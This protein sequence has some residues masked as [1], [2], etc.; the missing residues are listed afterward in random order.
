[1]NAAFIVILLIVIFAAI[2]MLNFYLAEQRRK[3]LRTWASAR[4]LSFQSCRDD[5]LAALHMGFSCFERGGNRYAYN[6]AQGANGQR[7]IQAFD[8]HYETK[9][10]KGQ[11]HHHR[12]SAVVV[13]AGLP[14]K[15]LSIRGET[16]FDG[17]GT[18]FGLGDIELES[19]EFNRRFHVTSPD[20]RWAFDALP[21]ATM[22]FLLESP[23]FSIEIQYD[24]MIA[25]TGR[26][27]SAPDFDAALNVL[28]GFLDRIP[29]TVLQELK[30]ACK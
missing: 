30:D 10:S 6:I 21:Q 26:V 13:R 3:E 14:L 24:C 20:R 18:F 8:Y 9:G 5:S 27:F 28:N 7:S 17:V 29:P 11:T 2:A 15:P 25:H 16:L 23:P 22:E 1:M 19:A 4:G 12:F